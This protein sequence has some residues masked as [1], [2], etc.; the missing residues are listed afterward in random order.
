MAAVETVRAV[1]WW[2]EPTKDQ[3]YAFV[4]AW[5]GWTLDAFDFTI[6]LL[7]M[8]PIA[9]EF[10]VPL[11]DVTIVFTL[12]L[13]MRLVGATASGWMAD[14]LGRKTPLMISIAWYSVCNFIAGF[15]P[16]FW[17]LLLFRALLGF[18][19]GAEWPAGASLAMET[20]PIR[21]RGFMSGVLQGSW[22]LGFLASS[23]VYGL[24]YNYIGWRGMLWVGIAPALALV[25]IRYFVKEPEVWLENRKLQRTQKREVKVPLLTIFKRGVLANTLTTCW[26][27]AAGFVTYYSINALFA[28]H[29]QKDLGLSPALIATPLVFANLL[30]FLASSGWGWVSDRL[31][32]RPAMIIPA[33]CAIPLVPIYLFSGNFTLVV[34]AF[35][36]QGIFAGGGMYGQVPSYLTERFPTEI[37][38]TATGFCYHVGAIPGAMVPPILTT[39]A[40]YW[41]TSLAIP[42]L[43]GT[44][45]GLTNFIL[46]VVFGPET[47]GTEMVPDLVVA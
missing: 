34:I 11:T 16:T 13:W 10:K 8:V 33:L 15:S 43:I 20:W 17:F 22:G 1:P 36:A 21:S 41:G 44:L 23:A 35:I 45:F 7:I 42:M 3:W 2:K 29:L 46:S 38:G 19:M 25:Y 26:F 12:T 40:A 31:G 32:R 9:E 18:G 24:F 30:V 39:L 27:Q 6:F 37:R 47:K 28:T 5:L 4:A 14:R